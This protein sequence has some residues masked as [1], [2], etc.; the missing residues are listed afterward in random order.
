MNPVFFIGIFAAGAL[1]W[2]L[3]SFLYKPI[4]CIVGRLVDDAQKAMT[5]EKKPKRK[6]K[7]KKEKN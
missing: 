1:L 3:L 7:K 6:S 4:G 5:E 2:L